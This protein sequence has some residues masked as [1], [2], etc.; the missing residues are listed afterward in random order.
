M[1]LDDHWIK[2]P[3]DKEGISWVLR[4]GPPDL[5]D[6]NYGSVGVEKEWSKARSEATVKEPLKDGRMKVAEQ[7]YLNLILLPYTF[8]FETF[9]G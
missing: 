8:D 5:F 3:I 7:S 6:P 2:S 4:T 9:S 1:E